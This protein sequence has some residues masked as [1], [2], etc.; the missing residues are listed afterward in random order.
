MSPSP[1]RAAATDRHHG[2][3]RGAAASRV[4]RRVSGPTRPTR[5]TRPVHPRMVASGGA[6][7][8]PRPGRGQPALGRGALRRAL[9]L[10]DHPLL[11]RLL[12][13]R[14]WIALIGC[15]LIGIIPAVMTSS[16][17]INAPALVGTLVAVLV[18]GLG[19]SSIAVR[20]SGAHVTTADLRRE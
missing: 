12:T 3:R 6:V 2:A 19:A 13:G 20:M 9:A 1:A 10:V 18:I 16:R 17:S 11:V 7:A 15:A 5:P 14:A 4:P 8:L